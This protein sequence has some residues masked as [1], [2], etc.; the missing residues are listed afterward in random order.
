[1]SITQV[2]RFSK[3]LMAPQLLYV[4]IS[5]KGQPHTLLYGVGEPHTPNAG[6]SFDTADLL[7]SPYMVLGGSVQFFFLTFFLSVLYTS[8]STT[9]FTLSHFFYLFSPFQQ[10]VH[11]S[12]THYQCQSCSNIGWHST[13]LHRQCHPKAA[14]S[15][16]QA[17]PI[18][19]L[20]RS[21]LLNRSL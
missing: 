13:S 6:G 19:H 10:H 4:F 5:T 14:C 21:A 2:L 1:M 20:R 7:S 9:S 18:H 15:A 11:I 12:F 8:Q 16:Q 17:D 3:S